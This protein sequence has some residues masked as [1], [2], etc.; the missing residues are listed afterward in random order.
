MKE[1]Y[2]LKI[3]EEGANR[4]L[5][6]MRGQTFTDGT[7]VDTNK[8]VA[9]DKSIRYMY[10]AST[11]FG[12]TELN[13]IGGTHYSAPNNTIYPVNLSESEIKERDHRPSAEMCVAWSKYQAFLATLPAEEEDG[14][15]GKTGEP[16]AAAKPAP[17]KKTLRET[18]VS[19]FEIPTVDKNGFYVAAQTWETLVRN[20]FRKK[21]TLLVGPS[22]TGKTEIVIEAARQMNYQLCIYDMGSMHDPLTQML[23][24]H[25]I[26]ADHKSVFDYAQ[27]VHDVSEAPSEGFKGKIILLDE[28]SRAPQTTLNILFPC[29]D[30]RRSL[31]VEMAGEKDKRNIAIHPD[32]AFVA[33]A[34]IGAEYTGTATMDKAFVS[35]FLPF[36]LS[37]M[38]EEDEIAV[39]RKRTG[40][41]RDDAANIVRVCTRVRSLCKK[42]ELSNDVSTREA[43]RAAEFVADGWTALEAMRLTFLPLFEGDEV[44]GERSVVKKIFMAY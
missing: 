19:E 36:E 35:R 33:T 7:P 8:H 43:I 11:V 20:I 25:R 24:T 4:R 40:I 21:N 1:F 34:N 10:P 26:D 39:L 18:L 31:P 17:R 2:F 30:V 37:Y 29:L 38:Q 16:T 6:P 41:A 28:A 22:G 27:F 3:K 42:G 9:A 15:F 32:V 23:G 14:L 44:D 12:C 13:C 5:V